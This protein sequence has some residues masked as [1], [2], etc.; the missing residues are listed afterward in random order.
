[1]KEAGKIIAKTTGVIR[2][3]AES[4]SK[5]ILLAKNSVMT[6]L[7]RPRSNNRK[8]DSL[9]SHLQSTSGIVGM[10]S[11]TCSRGINEKSQRSTSCMTER[12]DFLISGHQSAARRQNAR[13]PACQ[14]KRLDIETPIRVVG[15][16]ISI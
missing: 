6:Q 4:E 16:S 8:L 1:M 9:S 15:L 2:K 3:G 5:V 10:E 14:R 12:E 13:R 7:N 11:V